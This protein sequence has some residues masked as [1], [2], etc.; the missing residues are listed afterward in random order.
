MRQAQAARKAEDMTPTTVQLNPATAATTLIGK[1]AHIA[2]SKRVG[3]Q[4]IK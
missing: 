4:Q 3:E 2:R 1:G